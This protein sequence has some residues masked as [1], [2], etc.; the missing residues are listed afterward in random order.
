MFVDFDSTCVVIKDPE[1]FLARVQAAIS[2]ALPGWRCIAAPVEYFDPFFSRP[3]QMA[4]QL[5]KHFRYCYQKEFRLL[6][7]PPSENAAADHAWNHISF[8]IGPI[9]AYGEIIHVSSVSE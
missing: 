1:E 3:H 6:W 2:P 8:E 9:T 5:F 4:A 7:V